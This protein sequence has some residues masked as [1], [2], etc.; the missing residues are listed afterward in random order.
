MTRTVKLPDRVSALF[1]PFWIPIWST[2]QDPV[3]KLVVTHMSN[4][5]RTELVP[6]LEPIR[7]LAEDWYHKG[8]SH[9]DWRLQLPVRGSAGGRQKV[10]VWLY[11]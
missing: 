5:V 8:E 6:V 11:G 1:S 9:R 7:R 3:S 4:H 10:S 2:V